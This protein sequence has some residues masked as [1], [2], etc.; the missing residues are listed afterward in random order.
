MGQQ[1]LRRIEL[2]DG[3][4][5]GDD[6]VLPSQFWTALADPRSEPEKRL[7]VAV[8]EDA[9]AVLVAGGYNAE[10]K[11]LHREAE[12]WFASDDRGAPFTFAAICDVLSLDV[13]RVRQALAQWQTRPRAFRRPRLQAGRGRHQLRSGERG[14][15]RAA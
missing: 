10:R 11:V 4:L 8:L 1:G 13:G 2:D 5:G 15:R 6:T 7:M 12:Q 14:P 3:E 9:I